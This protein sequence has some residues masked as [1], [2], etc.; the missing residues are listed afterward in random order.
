VADLAVPHC[1]EPYRSSRDLPYS[2]AHRTGPFATP[3][4]RPR[5]MLDCRFES[6]H[7]KPCPS[8]KYFTDSLLEGL[9][10]VLTQQ[11]ETTQENQRRDL[12]SRTV[13]LLIRS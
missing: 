9:A 12:R 1:C 2:R 6:Y 3:A 8:V 5:L 4:P 13:R 10:I 11:L 7:G